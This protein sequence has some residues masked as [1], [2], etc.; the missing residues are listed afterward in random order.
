[1]H[2]VICTDPDLEGVSTAEVSLLEAHSIAQRQG[3]AVMARRSCAVQQLP[4][5]LRATV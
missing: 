3:P 2:V 1:M 4:R 5:I